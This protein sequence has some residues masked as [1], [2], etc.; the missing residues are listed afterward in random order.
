MPYNPDNWRDRE[1]TPGWSPDGD[2]HAMSGGSA[3]GETAYDKDIDRD[4]Q[5]GAAAQGTAPVTL[6]QTQANESRGLQMGALGLLRA[7]GDGSAPSS[8]G[9]LAQRAN[10]NA[11]RQAGAQVAGARSAGGGI[12]ALRGAGNTAGDAMLAGNAHNADARAGEISH[13]QNAYAGG[14]GTVNKQDLGA[15][16]ANAQ[17]AAQQRAVDEQRQQYFERQAYDTRGF[18]RQVSND[19]TAMLHRQQQ[20]DRAYRDARSQADWDKGKMVVGTVLS[21]GTG[22]ASSKLDTSTPSYDDPTAGSDPRM[23]MHIGSLASLMKGRR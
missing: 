8:A 10:E 11:V 1:A 23:K 15:A 21:G 17:L 9:I 2:G 16:T 5:M 22:L 20:A 13:G 14:A 19:N 6:D 4:R 7:Q 18:Q 12:A 3:Y